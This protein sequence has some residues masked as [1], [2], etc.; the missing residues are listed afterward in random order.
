MSAV[1][2]VLGL[3]ATLLAVP[4]TVYALQ[5][6]AGSLLPDRRRDPDDELP[7]RT[8]V[9]VPAHDEE[10]VVADTVRG[11]VHAVARGL[12][13]R[14]E[15]LVV[16][17]NCQD[18]TAARAR[19][20]GARVLE[21]NDPDRRGKGFAIAFGARALEQTPPDVVVLVDADCRT[22]PAALRH[23]ALRAA[24][25][26]RPVQADYILQPPPNPTPTSGI[27][28]LAV[29]VKN[30]VRPRGMR[31]LGLPCQLTGSGMAMR[32]T[33]LRGAPET[34][35]DIVEDMVLGVELALQGR[36]PT[37]TSAAEVWSQ[38]PAGRSA[39]AGQRR[40]W[41]HGHL[42]TMLRYAPRLLLHGLA[43]L[44][45]HRLALALDLLVPPMA[46]LVLATT[47]WAACCWSAHLLGSATW[48]LW[49]SGS[50]LAAVALGTL[51]AWAVHGRRTLPLR[52]LVFVPIYVLWKV[53]LYLAFFLRKGQRSWNR[54]ARS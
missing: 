35:A 4:A 15:V 44:S 9:L 6:I 14:G 49:I 41:E 3:G 19:D 28:G 11:L 25:G 17:D 34:G 7:E 27:S 16:A 53:P 10:V 29:L 8:V 21:R 31:R 51:T 45:P 36:P 46:L 13:G 38:L 12:D 24:A 26:E 5:C 22:T 50:A 37:S 40:R 18:A 47:T 23:L 30:R 33:T 52:H 42:A 2:A 20:A 54:T 32:Y 1:D 39:A 43:K 48:P